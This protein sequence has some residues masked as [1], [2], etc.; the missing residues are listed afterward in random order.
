MLDLLIFEVLFFIPAPPPQYIQ[1][2]INTLLIISIKYGFSPF[3]F[4]LSQFC[5]LFPPLSR[6]KKCEHIKL[7]FGPFSLLRSIWSIYVQFSLL[8]STLVKFNPFGQ[9][10]PLRSIRSILVHFSL[11][12]FNKLSPFGL[13][14]FT[15]VHSVYFG[16]L[17]TLLVHFDPLLLDNAEFQSSRD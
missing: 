16:L 13:F 12:Q 1:R 10:G 2:G 3:E 11:F 7:S 14:Q 17:G 6:P 4:L 15:S 9:F 5:Y 8:Q